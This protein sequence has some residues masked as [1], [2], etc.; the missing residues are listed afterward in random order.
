MT[1]LYPFRLTLNTD[2]SEKREKSSTKHFRCRYASSIIHPLLRKYVVVKLSFAQGAIDLSLGQLRRSCR[3]RGKI[4]VVCLEKLAAK[5]KN[6]AIFFLNNCYEIR[7]KPRLNHLEKFRQF[8]ILN[9]GENFALKFKLEENLAL[10]FKLE[11][12]L[13]WIWKKR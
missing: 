6:S 13:V 3:K 5:F 8:N 4:S 11:E 10:K 9:C 7:K 12:N 1:E 2:L